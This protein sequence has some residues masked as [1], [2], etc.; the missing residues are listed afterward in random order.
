[1]QDNADLYLEFEALDPDFKIPSK[2]KFPRFK[3][4][5]YLIVNKIWLNNTGNCTLIEPIIKIKLTPLLGK[6][7]IFFPCC[8]L[9]TEKNISVGELYYLERIWDPKK[10]Y[11]YADNFGGNQ[12]GSPIVLDELGKWKIDIDIALEEEEPDKINIISHWSIIHGSI[13]R[14]SFK[15][16]TLDDLRAE[17]RADLAVKIAEGTFWI[18]VLSFI[19]LFG[20]VLTN[21][22]LIKLQKEQLPKR[23]SMFKSIS[24][25]IK[26]LHDLIRDKIDKKRLE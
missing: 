10:V 26:K 13:T 22:Y 2:Y 6:S 15:V 5:D 17:E 20:S 19:G 4:K 7:K 3:E 11:F 9:Y 25:R 12:S 21:L 23:E 14:D 18:A 24:R 8:G 1:M 16:Y